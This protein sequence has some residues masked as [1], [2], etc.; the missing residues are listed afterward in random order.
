MR[1]ILASIQFLLIMCYFIYFFTFLK[2]L[3]LN[4]IFHVL[5]FKVNFRSLNCF[6]GWSYIYVS[7]RKSVKF[8]IF[9]SVWVEH[10]FLKIFFNCFRWRFFWRVHY[11]KVNFR[12]LKYFEGWSYIYVSIRKS[13][14]NINY[15]FSAPCFWKY[16][17]F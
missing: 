11:F 3:F 13:V 6:E 17:V 12:A 16:Y 10:V 4:V 7:I 14:K 2:A 5:I 15:H 1:R 9:N 8:I